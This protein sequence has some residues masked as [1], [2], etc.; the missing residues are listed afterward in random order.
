MSTEDNTNTQPSAIAQMN[1]IL[2]KKELLIKEKKEELDAYKKELEIFEQELQNKVEEVKKGQAEILEEK[3]KIDEAWKEIRAYEEKLQASTNEVLEEKIK[4]E[5]LQKDFLEKELNE[6]GNSDSESRLNLSKLRASIGITV[7]EPVAHEEADGTKEQETVKEDVDEIPTLFRDLEMEIEKSYSKWNV[8]EMMK[9]RYCLKFEEKEI[10]FFDNEPHPEV[11]IVV[12]RRN[13]KA[14][15]RLQ[16]SIVNL[17]R[18][19]P[20]WHITTDENRVIYTMP[21]T[22]DTKTAVV[23]KKCSEFMKANL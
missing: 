8:L 1:E 16:S 20:E 10:R 11:Q 22:K 21:F 3:K 15:K 18:V 12:F 13:A 14:D 23:L 2:T 19:A 5:E 7:E 4:F 17:E 9:D 6:Q